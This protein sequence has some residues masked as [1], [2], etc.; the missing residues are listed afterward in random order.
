[1]QETI[2]LRDRPNGMEEEY[3][4]I[5]DPH[6]PIVRRINDV[7]RS[8]ASRPKTILIDDLENIDQAARSGVRLDSLYLT[9]GLQLS[10]G[11][12]AT[13]MYGQL[14]TYTLSH[15]VTDGLFGGEKRARVFALAE[16]PRPARLDDLS[17]RD[18][19]IVVLDGVRLV[20]NIGAITRTSAGFSAA[21]LVLLESGLRNA[22]DRRLIRASRGLVFAL[23]VV[24][25]TTDEF[26]EYVLRKRTTV[27]TLT[28]HAA[29]S[30]ESVGG[31]RGRMALVLGSERNGLSE[32]LD[33]IAS[34]KYS[35]PMSPDLE[36]LNVS[37]SAGI[38]LY[39]RNRS[40]QIPHITTAQ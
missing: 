33:G 9:E 27:G 30:L 28:A 37:V 7:L 4:A 8:R 16:A 11:D 36:S 17:G 15:A 39:E 25:A 12:G 23:P 2:S 31:I 10:S 29:E 3:A 14:P 32:Q 19:D 34:Y 22:F 1:M 24:L 21:G 38:A 6:H 35:I 40:G 18:G 26:A 20:G 5:S 13:P